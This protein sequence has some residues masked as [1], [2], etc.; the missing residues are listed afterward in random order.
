MSVKEVLIFAYIKLIWE[1]YI[2]FSYQYWKKSITMRFNPTP[3]LSGKPR[4]QFYFPM[5]RLRGELLF[6]YSMYMYK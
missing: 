4:A 5:R 6:V 2:H 1:S 3:L